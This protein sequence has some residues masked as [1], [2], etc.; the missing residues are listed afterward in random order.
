MDFR[1]DVVENFAARELQIS[2]FS[3][4]CALFSAESR[5]N[6]EEQPFADSLVENKFPTRTIE[7]LT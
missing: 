2:A 5:A 6:D 7:C 1:F 3:N 4:S